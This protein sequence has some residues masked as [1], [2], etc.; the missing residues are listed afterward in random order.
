MR[1]EIVAV[2]TE[3]L[4]GQ[5][6]NTNAQTI[7][8][9]LATIGVD[10]L[11]HTVVGDNE[12]RIA[13]L[14][15]QALA[16][17]D[18]VIITGGLGPTHDDLTREAIAAATR[19]PLERRPELE[20]DLSDRFA[21]FGRP[22]AETNL[23]Q[24]DQPKGAVAIPNSRGSA[25]GIA[26]DVGGK[27]IYAM[28]GVP[29]EM[30]TMLTESVLPRIASAVGGARLVSRVLK[31]VG[32][33]E[34]DVAERLKDVISGLDVSRSATI[35]M[36]PGAG[37]VQIRITA[38][39][40]NEEQA[41]GPIARVEEE[42]RRILGPAVFGA[43]ADTLESVVARLMIERGL[44]LAIAESVTGGMLA[45]SLV[46]VPGASAFLRAGFV[47]YSIASKA[48]IGVPRDLLDLHGSISEPTTIALAQAARSRAGADLG[49]ATTGEAG[50]EPLERRAGEVIVALSWGDDSIARAFR[51]PGDR[52]LVRRWATRGAL[53]LLRLWL[54]GELS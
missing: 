51:V 39:G 27:W 16:R 43:D 13:E 24:A 8:E 6:A 25:P 33:P 7:S 14:I 48:D 12:S 46:E 32:V 20:Q 44:T 49:L 41:R 10:V 45:S 47:T 34:S 31:V 3:I 4:L 29:H 19:R 37:E 50:P 11:F 5:I 1:A 35:A 40:V 26:L 52:A 23:R 42:V 38:K 30:E 36:L 28:P 21:R 17:S 53:N 9:A 22:M 2:G 18:V 15:E 54:M